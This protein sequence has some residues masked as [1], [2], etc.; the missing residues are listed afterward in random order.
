[1]GLFAVAP[2]YEIGLALLLVAGFLLIAFTAMAQ[3]IVQVHAPQEIRGR[4]LGLYNMANLG[5]RS[6]SGLTV[7]MLGSLVGIHWSLGLSAGALFLITLGL[8]VFERPA[9]QS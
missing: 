7:G 4:V 3:T 2:S 6:G 1:M 9:A 8:L 5:L